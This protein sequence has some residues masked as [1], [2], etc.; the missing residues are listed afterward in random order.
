[1]LF[2]SP[3]VF[4]NGNHLRKNCHLSKLA[5]RSSLK[6][7]RRCFGCFKLFQELPP[8][9]I[10]SCTTSCRLCKRRSM[11]QHVCLCTESGSSQSA[12]N[13]PRNQDAN[14]GSGGSES[15]N[16]GQNGGAGGQ[17]G[18][19]SATSSNTPQ[20]SAQSSCPQQYNQ[21]HMR[22][23]VARVEPEIEEAVA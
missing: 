5:R 16:H 2:R 6:Q 22:S 23:T 12:R 3:C 8:N 19:G 18:A 9:H 10:P 4:C 15:R 14:P 7:Q 21:N 1:M 13:Q 20:T 17:N 11:N